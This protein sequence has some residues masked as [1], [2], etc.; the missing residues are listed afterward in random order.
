MLGF[1][2]LV[3]TKLIYHPILLDMVSMLADLTDWFDLIVGREP[4]E[5]IKVSAVFTASTTSMEW[6]R[7]FQQS[8]PVTP[9]PHRTLRGMLS[10]CFKVHCNSGDD[11]TN[12]ENMTYPSSLKPVMCLDL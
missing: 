6:G 5:G 7:I 4:H 2:D 10:P 3:S 12:E 8:M 9:K 1:G 11:W